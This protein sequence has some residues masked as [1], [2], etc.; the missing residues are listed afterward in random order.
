MYKVFLKDKRALAFFNK[1]ASASFWDAHWN[2]DDHTAKAI[3]SVRNDGMFTPYALRYLK[4]GS[5]VI[6]G[7]CGKGQIVNAL[8]YHGFESVGVDFAVETVKALNR[9]LPELDI[10]YGDVFELPLEDSSFDG[11]I[12]GGVIEHFWDGN[13]IILEEMHRVL[14]KGGFLF[15]TFPY[16][17]P[18]R[19]LKALLG[20]YEVKKMSEL[21]GEQ[22]AF[23]QFALNSRDTINTFRRIGFQL[24]E[25][26][27]ADGIK[28]F[29]SE[30]SF[31]RKFLQG[32]YDRKHFRG[33]R[34]YLDKMLTPFSGHI[35]FLVFQ[36]R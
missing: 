10:R 20:L 6:E 25:S 14:K 11:Y 31:F 35:L 15:I 36:K 24:M 8:R 22:E 12:S 13:D 28:G 1:K 18:L 21:H 34:P 2:F 4:P 27:P 32:V 9:Y 30:V 5:K 3:K 17:S 23:Y 19:K 33:L 29:K 16:M 26:K 7:G